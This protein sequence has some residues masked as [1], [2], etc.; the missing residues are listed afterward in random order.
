MQG[1]DESMPSSKEANLVTADAVIKFMM[2][3]FGNENA[4]ITRELQMVLEL[5]Y[6]TEAQKFITDSSA[7]ARRD[8]K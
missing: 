7:F 4:D 2:D 6:V 5:C 8:T 1:A 3:T